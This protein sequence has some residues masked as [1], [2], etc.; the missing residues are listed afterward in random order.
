MCEPQRQDL[1]PSRARVRPARHTE[2]KMQ[3]AADA[4]RS[5]DHHS[6]VD[7]SARITEL[8]RGV[9]FN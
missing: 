8:L 1:G 7:E 5:L 6:V 9:P 4:Q 2:A 3:S